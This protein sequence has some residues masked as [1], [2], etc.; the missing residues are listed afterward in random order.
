MILL[1]VCGATFLLGF[2]SHRNQVFPYSILQGTPLHSRDEHDR[3]V[4]ELHSQ[5]FHRIAALPYLN[6]TFDQDHHQKGVVTADPARSFPGFNF[7]NSRRAKSAQLI[8]MKGQV[9]HEWS[10]TSPETWQSVELLPDGDVLVIE[11]D[12]ELIRLDTKSRLLWRFKGRVHHDLD[13][14]EEKIYVLNRREAVR[15]EIHTERNTLVDFISIITRDGIETEQVS[16]LDLLLTSPYAYLLPSLDRNFRGSE[17]P[18][19]D[20]LHTNHI[21]II[22]GR[23]EHRCPVLKRGNILLS[24]GSLNVIMIVDTD[25]NEIVWLWGPGN[26]ALQHHPQLLDNGNLL[27]FDNGIEKSRVLELDPV[28]FRI[29]WSYEADDFFSETRGSVQRLPN[30]NTLITES[31]TGYVIEVDEAGQ[32]VWKFVNPDVDDSGKRG[33]IWRMTRFTSEDLPFLQNKD[34]DGSE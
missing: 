3:E 13:V 9:I 2:Y 11:K 5:A 26:L 33:A 24:L 32:L 10:Y 29:N 27:V 20:I 28:S 18:A 6:A 14:F 19:L 23:L 12:K 8:D 25:T 31:D 30:G 1:L 34:L 7:Y 22:D 21:E 15:P 4:I 17:G 16:I